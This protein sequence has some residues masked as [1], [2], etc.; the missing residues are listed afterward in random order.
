VPRRN[1]SDD[2]QLVRRSLIRFAAP[3]DPKLAA[4][5]RR[6]AM[7]WIADRQAV[8][9]GMVDSVLLIAAETGDAATFDAL[10]AEA[11]A[12]SDS[13][14]RRNL[15]V[16]LLSFTDPV[17]AR[18]GLGIMLDPSFDIRESGTALYFSN[19]SIPPRRETHAFIAANFEALAKRVAR[20]TPAYWPAYAAGLCNESDRADVETFWRDR[21]AKYEGGERTLK[22]ALEQ[23]H[24]CTVLR[25]AQGQAVAAF[26][27]K[28]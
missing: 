23:I 13:L 12:T 10:L 5:A 1:E 20:D 24:L 18:R 22:Q 27:A 14:D 19:K 6:L 28:H 8:D 7:A 15:M 9:P 26:L 16:A 3:E 25:A 11:K 21:I 2:D 17:L 4:E